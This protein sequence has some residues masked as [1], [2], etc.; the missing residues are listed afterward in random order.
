MVRIYPAHFL[1]HYAF[2]IPD[3]EL[4]FFTSDLLFGIG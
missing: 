3:L 2:Q 1:V 4:P